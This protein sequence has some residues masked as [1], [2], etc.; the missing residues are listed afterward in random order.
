MFS[1]CNLPFSTSNTLF[2]NGEQLGFVLNV[3]I[4]NLFSLN[5]SKQ[6]SFMLSIDR[7][8]VIIYN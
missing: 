3:D 2:F 8:R 6:I 5:I 7:D 1:F 4:N